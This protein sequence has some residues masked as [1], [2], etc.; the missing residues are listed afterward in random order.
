M[1]TLENY[2]FVKEFIINSSGE[3]DKV[4]VNL[5]DYQK[6]VELEEDEGIYRAVLEVKI[7]TLLSLSDALQELYAE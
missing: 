7:E 6:L 1:I 3:V 5:G 4:I 2:P